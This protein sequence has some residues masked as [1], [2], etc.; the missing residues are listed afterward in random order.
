MHNGAIFHTSSIVFPNKRALPQD[1]QEIDISLAL[2]PTLLNNK[3]PSDQLTDSCTQMKCL[4]TKDNIYLFFFI[5][6]NFTYNIINYS[7]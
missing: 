3:L 5:T 1:T 6:N 4:F 2:D 7:Y